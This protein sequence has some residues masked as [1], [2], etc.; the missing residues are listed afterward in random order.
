MG[1][2]L[3]KLDRVQNAALQ[4]IVGRHPAQVDGR[5]ICHATPSNKESLSMARVLTPKYHLPID[6]ALLQVPTRVSE[7]VPTYI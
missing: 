1:I 4:F 3:E 5:K 6:R 7:A 2:S